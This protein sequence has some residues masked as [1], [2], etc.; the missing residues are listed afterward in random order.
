M[1]RFLLYLDDLEDAWYAVA[2][3]S[4]RIRRG[5]RAMGL[6]TFAA[7]VQ[8]LAVLVALRDPALGAAVASLLT[9]TVLYRSA[10][11][12]IGTSL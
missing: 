11:A 2:L 10:T 9:V 8:V 7:F 4:E 12:S 1:E 5:I 6:M 3:V